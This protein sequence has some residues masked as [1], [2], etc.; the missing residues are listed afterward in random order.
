MLHYN[1]CAELVPPNMTIIMCI[2]RYYTDIILHMATNTPCSIHGE[3][4]III[5]KTLMQIYKKALL[6]EDSEKKILH[7]SYSYFLYQK[8]DDSDRKLILSIDIKC[9]LWFARSIGYNKIII[10]SDAI[11]DLGY[12][13]Y[14]VDGEMEL[15]LDSAHIALISNQDS[16]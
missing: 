1:L 15:C 7:F 4:L 14:W 10:L 5:S 12:A 9:A 11:M 13:N 8:E 16:L 6:M 2:H 3:Y